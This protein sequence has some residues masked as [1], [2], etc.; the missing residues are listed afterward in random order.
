M[1]KNYEVFLNGQSTGLMVVNSSSEQEA[2]DMVWFDKHGK[3]PEHLRGK[4]TLKEIKNIHVPQMFQN[5]LMEMPVHIKKPLW[6]KI[7]NLFKRA[8]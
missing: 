2:L 6:E 3:A 5:C 8:S 7:T 4:A 1:K